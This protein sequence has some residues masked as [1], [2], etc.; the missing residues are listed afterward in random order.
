M[1][2]YDVRYGAEGVFFSQEELSSVADFD[3]VMSNVSSRAAQTGWSVHRYFIQTI[4][5]EL[6]RCGVNEP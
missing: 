2:V 4:N 6:R 1:V 3:L 5:L